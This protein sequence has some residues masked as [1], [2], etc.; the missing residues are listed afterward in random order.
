MKLLITTQ[1]YENYA[2]SEDGS[3]GTGAEAYWKPKGGDEYIVRD[4]QNEEE[5][6]VAVMALREEIET[7]NDYMTETIIDYQLVKDDYL[8]D[9]ERDQLEYDGKITYPAKE[10]VWA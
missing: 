6:T 2:W 7:A 9:F 5:A 1:V 3:I 10:L 8:T 4:I